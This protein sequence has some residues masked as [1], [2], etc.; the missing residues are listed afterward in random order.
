MSIPP[1]TVQMAV[2]RR[3]EYAKRLKKFIY[4]PLYPVQLTFT[5]APVVTSA[6]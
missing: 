2:I 1:W 4:F 3:I 5:D 6:A